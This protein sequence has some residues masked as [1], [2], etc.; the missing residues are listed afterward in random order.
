M[1][2]VKTP[3][4]AGPDGNHSMWVPAYKV[5]IL[6]PHN[7]ALGAATKLPPCWPKL[8]TYE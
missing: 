4:K 8:G 2:M 7:Q 1:P 3:T 5:H 6:E